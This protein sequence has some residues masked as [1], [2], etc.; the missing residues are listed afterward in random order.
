MYHFCAYNVPLI[1]QQPWPHLG[2]LVSHPR[3]FG[4]K[5][6]TDEF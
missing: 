3:T 2:G 4:S 6:I 1:K 5:H